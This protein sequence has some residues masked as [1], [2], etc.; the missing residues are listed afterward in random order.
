MSI[1][2][3]YDHRANTLI[4]L[5]LLCVFFAMVFT[6]VPSL[7]YPTLGQA[8]FSPNYTLEK[9]YFLQA[10]LLHPRL[11]LPFMIYLS[12]DYP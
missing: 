2:P 9:L 3:C 11:E 7:L 5:G 10:K 4:R 12:Y 1:V 6:M 8:K